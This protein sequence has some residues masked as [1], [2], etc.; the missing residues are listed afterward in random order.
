VK[1]SDYIAASDLVRVRVA[2]ELIRDT[3]PTSAK[4]TDRQKAVLQELYLWECE[5]FDK[6]DR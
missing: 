2:T 5:L 4:V 1:E 3:S 6:V